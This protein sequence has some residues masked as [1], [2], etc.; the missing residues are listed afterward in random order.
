MRAVWDGARVSA[1][2]PVGLILAIAIVC[3]VV[4]VVTSAR[5][6]HEVALKHDEEL[7]LN[8]IAEQRERVLREL[9]SVATT[10]QAVKNIHGATDAQ[11]IDSNV[12]QPLKT[13]FSHDYVIAV[14][15]DDRIIYPVAGARAIDPSWFDM[16][17]PDLAPILDHIRGRAQAGESARPE[18]D[19]LARP[20]F[21]P[22]RD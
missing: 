8:A 12:A 3:I 2:L 22:R 11:W 19:Q 18:P 20:R 5:R 13:Y 14:D 7:L 1:V 21:N 6:A 10:E 17:R 15:A 16:I 4:A 9:E